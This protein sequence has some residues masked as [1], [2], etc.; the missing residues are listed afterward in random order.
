MRNVP[1]V[2]QLAREVPSGFGFIENTITT[3]I[4]TMANMRRTRSNVV[5]SNKQEMAITTV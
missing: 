3:I 2:V 1:F 5:I 4:M